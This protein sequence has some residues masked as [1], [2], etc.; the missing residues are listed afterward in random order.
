MDTQTES[1]STL[2][3]NT[4]IET[5][6]V[7]VG[8][9][10]DGVLAGFASA[11]VRRANEEGADF[12]NH[13]TEWRTW[14][15]KEVFPDTFGDIWESIADDYDFWLDEI[16]PLEKAHVNFPVAAYVTSRRVPSEVS[17]A[18]LDRH[19]FPEAPVHTVGIGESKKETLQRE[20]IDVFVD[21]KVSTVVEL[22]EADI[23]A[24]LKDSPA[25]QQAPANIPR[26]NYLSELPGRLRPSLQVMSR[27]MARRI[28][29]LDRLTLSGS[30][31]PEDRPV[32]DAVP[33]G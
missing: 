21:D 2:S 4:L 10:I 19:G 20:E 28:D 31:R 9:D 16:M 23:M 26:I 8:L 32:P 14:E 18:W 15:A 27:A 5:L 30:Y 33:T 25:N 7:R 13:Y 11:F 22:R 12:F 29:T 17:A 24:Y 6:G 1:I 3:T